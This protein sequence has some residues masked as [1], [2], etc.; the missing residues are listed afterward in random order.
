MPGRVN[1]APPGLNGVAEASAVRAVAP[2]PSP[3][4]EPPAPGS[5]PATLALALLAFHRH[6]GPIFKGTEAKYG[7]FADL[8]AVLEVVTTPLL[9]QGHSQWWP[10]PAANPAAA[11]PQRRIDQ[12]G[13]APADP[14]R[15]V[16]PPA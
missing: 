6:V 8:H 4:P 3:N 1:P 14:Q 7:K 9:D 15:D 16:G 11:C 13:G 12:F 2:T 5:Y 10:E